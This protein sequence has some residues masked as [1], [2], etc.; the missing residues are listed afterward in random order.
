MAENWP[1]SSALICS[2]LSK[3][4]N[5]YVKKNVQRKIF[6]KIKRFVRIKNI[7]PHKKIFVQIAKYISK[8]QFSY[9]YLKE[10]ADNWQTGSAPNGPMVQ[11]YN[12]TMVSHA[13][14]VSNGPMVQCTMCT[15][16]SMFSFQPNKVRLTLKILF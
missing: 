3:L 1:A 6:V 16:Y 15:L 10:L 14:M 4:Q 12:A 8:S 11:C 7:C 9:R 13:T 2:F 5:E